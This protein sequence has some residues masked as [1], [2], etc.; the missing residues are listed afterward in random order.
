MALSALADFKAKC[1]AAILECVGAGNDHTDAWERAFASRGVSVAALAADGTAA[2]ATALTA[3][4]A[5]TMQLAFRLA[6]QAPAVATSRTAALLLVDVC[7]WV[8]S[9]VRGSC[10]VFIF[11]LQQH[12]SSLSIS[13]RSFCLHS[14]HSTRRR[15][16]HCS[17]IFSNNKCVTRYIISVFSFSHLPFRKR[18]ITH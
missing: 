15:H 18:Q 14:R 1:S 8:A 3:T 17:R 13:Q 16:S 11:W 6:L 2:T 7:T 9:N 4:D 12:L 10:C 5:Q